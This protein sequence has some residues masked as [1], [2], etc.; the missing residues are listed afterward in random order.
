MAKENQKQTPGS[1]MPD[2]LKDPEQVQRRIACDKAYPVVMANSVIKGRQPMNI[3]EQ[4]IFRL[5][6]S[7]VQPD[8]EQFQTFQIALPLLAKI[9]GIKSV[10][11]LR[12]DIGKIVA[13]LQTQYL[14]IRYFDE[15]DKD[16]TN[17][18]WRLVSIMAVSEFDGQF[19]RLQLSD[20]LRPYVLNLQGDYTSYPITTIAG[21]ESSYAMR[22]YEILLMT[23][24]KCYRKYDTFTVDVQMLKSVLQDPNVKGSSDKYA[25]YYNFKT[26]VLVPAIEQI[27]AN[28]LSEFTVDFTEVK[29]GG[30]AV[31]ELCFHITPR[32]YYKEV[33]EATPE[34]LQ[35]LKNAHAVSKQL[36]ENSV[37]ELKEIKE[38]TIFMGSGE[39]MSEG[40]PFKA[41]PPKTKPKSKNAVKQP[42][43]EANPK[44]QADSIEDF[45]NTELSTKNHSVVD[46]DT[47]NTYIQ[48]SLLD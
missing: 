37:C 16:K 36:A 31:A 5:L 3:R 7:Q 2:M 44:Y 32:G 12:R 22:I 23:Y 41:P 17:E 18:K 43:I 29:H 21:F 39:N 1:Y 45:V 26:R 24:N 33:S 15:E 47:D 4:K 30:K 28:Y 34:E 46:D 42:I 38:G 35:A 9:L 6:L 40:I 14:S 48:L 19:L 27:N 20:S 8:T 13:N 10:D 11:S 25:R